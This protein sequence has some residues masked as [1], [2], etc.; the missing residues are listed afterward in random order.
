MDSYFVDYRSDRWHVEF[1]TFDV[2]FPP[3]VTA[4]LWS[5]KNGD[6]FA[7]WAQVRL[8]GCADEQEAASAAGPLVRR[9]GGQ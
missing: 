4:R 3:N 7:L 1:P 5:D 6:W 9:C 8:D 2:A